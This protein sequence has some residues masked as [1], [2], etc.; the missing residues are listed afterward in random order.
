MLPPPPPRGSVRPRFRR[1]T[2]GSIVHRVYNPEKFGASATGYRR[3]GPVARMDHHVRP[4][5]SRRDRGIFYGAPTYRGCL[6]EVLDDR[7]LDLTNRRHAVLRITK[8]LTLLDLR[9]AGAMAAGVDARIGKCPHRESQPWARHFYESESYGRIDGF[10]WLNS[11]TDDEAFAF[12]ERA[13]DAY[14]V[15]VDVPLT[16]ETREIATLC[17]PLGVV[18]GPL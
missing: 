4:R 9:R 2:V 7:M 6:V 18:I 5:G 1:L 10:T 8:P 12:V 3:F 11:H 14:A 16:S 13:G 17:D 15:V